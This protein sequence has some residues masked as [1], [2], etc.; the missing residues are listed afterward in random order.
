LKVNH[1]FIGIDQARLL[2]LIKNGMGISNN[3][4]P[5][6]HGFLASR[7][8][9]NEHDILY[10]VAR[11]GSLGRPAILPAVLGVVLGTIGGEHVPRKIP[12]KALRRVVFAILL[13]VGVYL[14]I[15][16]SR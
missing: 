2:R 8:I 7:L 13:A 16:P 3:L 4:Q 15:T 10:T 5:F 6:A 1:R 12:Q 9:I 14:L 11:C